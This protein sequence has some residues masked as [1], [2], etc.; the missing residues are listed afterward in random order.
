MLADPLRLVTGGVDTHKDTHVASVVDHLGTCI[1]THA[2]ATTAVGYR[3]LT[4]W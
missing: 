3:A 2:F 4:P 1:G